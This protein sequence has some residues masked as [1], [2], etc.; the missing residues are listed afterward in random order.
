MPKRAKLAH[1]GLLAIIR[2]QV[3]IELTAVPEIGDDGSN[4]VVLEPCCNVLAIGA[5]SNGSV[6]L[7]TAALGEGLSVPGQGSVP[8]YVRRGMVPAVEV[9]V[10]DGALGK[11][12]R[13]STCRAGT[14]ARAA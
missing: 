3:S 14:R 4:I 6:V 12:Q 8:G 9:V 1:V 11:S 10:E 2:G 7:E 13:K 5:A